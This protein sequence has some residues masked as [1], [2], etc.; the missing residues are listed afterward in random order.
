MNPRRHGWQKLALCGISALLRAAW[1]A[2]DDPNRSQLVIGVEMEDPYWNQHTSI[3]YIIYICIIY[4]YIVIYIYIWVEAWGSPKGNLSSLFSTL[5]N[6]IIHCILQCFVFF[7]QLESTRNQFNMRTTYLGYVVCC[8]F[9]FFFYI[10]LK[11]FILSYCRRSQR[12]CVF[13]GI[14]GFL[15]L[16]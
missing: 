16:T 6:V 7:P 1:T 14:S 3:Q 15:W 12:N 11:L 13:F 9:L 8:L 5:T 4:I 2:A 10:F